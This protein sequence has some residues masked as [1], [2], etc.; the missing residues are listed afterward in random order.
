MSML[1]DEIID[2][3]EFNVL[4]HRMRKESLP[5]PLVYTI[6]NPKARSKIVPI[7]E[8]KKLTST[9]LQRISKISDK[10]GGLDHV[11]TLINRMAERARTYLHLF[12]GKNKDVKLLID[13]TV[14]NQKDWKPVLRAS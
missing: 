4:R 10:A 5:L 3:L 2:M 13:S 9:D 1:R 14:I 11:A 6:Q 12:Q 7:I 8:K